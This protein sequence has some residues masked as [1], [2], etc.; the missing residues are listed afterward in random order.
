[1]LGFNGG[2]I[3]KTNLTSQATSV[4]G[5]W[6]LQEQMKAVRNDLWAGS[7]VTN[8]LVLNLDASSYPGSGT[9]WTDL[10]GNGRNFTWVSS[11]SFTGGSKPYFSTLGNRCTGPASNSFGITN[12]SGYTI[13]LICEQNALVGTAAFKFYS[14]AG[15]P[16]SLAGRGIF[17]HCT[18][19]NDVV[20]FDQGGC[21]G[22]NTRTNVASGGSQTWN[23]WTFRRFTGSSTR[24][25]S[26]NGT[27]LVTNTAAAA[28]ID[29]SSTA[30][31]LGSS[32]ESGGNSS[33]WNA[34]L[35]GFIVYNRGLSDDE[36]QQNYNA[37]K[38][39]YI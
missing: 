4:P 25:I 18:W 8:G 27:T 19:S 26:K 20:Y 21:C 12:T 23:F 38:S 6:T 10:S 5:V 29:L 1:M 11:P 16:E 37:L 39:R 35:G 36:I 7:I 14:A 13:F 31:D 15:L 34:N 24:S 32:A 28:N 33:T 30:V 22:S 3:G 9:T 17:S 2:L